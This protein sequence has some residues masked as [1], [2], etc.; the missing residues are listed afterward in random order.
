MIEKGLNNLYWGFLFISINFRICGFDI[1]PDVIGFILFSL[2]FS[3]LK[4]HSDYFAKASTF[5]IF[6]IILSV[7]SVY[8]V[9]NNNGG[10]NFGILGP[11]S[12]LIGIVSIILTL[13][14]IYNLFMGMKEMLMNH[15]KYALAVEAEERWSQYKVLTIAS[16]LIFAIIFI[17]LL[18]IIYALVLLIF[19]IVF[20]VKTMRYISDCKQSFIRYNY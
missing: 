10:I 19:S 7:F 12:I 16:I 11:F 6:M 5:N 8:E 2:A 4:E 3:N 20:L 18:N 9:Q 13:L 17:P 14:V 15:D 1:L